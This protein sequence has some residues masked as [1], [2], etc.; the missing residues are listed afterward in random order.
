MQDN[1]IQTD[2]TNIAITMKIIVVIYNLF[3]VI[4]KNKGRRKMHLSIGQNLNLI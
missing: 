4:T 3:T 1:L 2:L